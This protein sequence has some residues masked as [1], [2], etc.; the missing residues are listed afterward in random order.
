MRSHRSDSSRKQIGLPDHV[1]LTQTHREPQC[2]TAGPRK[3]PNRSVPRGPGSSLVVLL[4]LRE[5][6]RRPP[7]QNRSTLRQ[8]VYDARIEFAQ[9]VLLDQLEELVDST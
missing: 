1:Q 8:T 5:N 4:S 9:L 6:A 2:G 7:D 3:V